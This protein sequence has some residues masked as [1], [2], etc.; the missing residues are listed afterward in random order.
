MQKNIAVFFGGV[1]GENEI[2]VITG[3]M[4][5]NVLRRGGYR[6]VPVY[7]TQSGEYVCGEALADIKNYA[8]GARPEG[9]AAAFVPG[10]LALLSRRGK[11]KERLPLYCAVNCCHGG[12]GEGGGISGLCRAMSVPLASAGVF[13]SAACLDKRLTKLLLSALG[14]P[15]L[16]YEYVTDVAGSRKIS[17]F[18]VVVKPVSL[19][20]SIGVVRADDPDQLAAAVAAA[21]ELDSG[22]IIERY[23]RDRRE[24]NC[25]VYASE[26]EVVVSPCEELRGGDLLTYDDKYSGGG[27]RIFPADIGRELSDRIRG[28]A[29]KVYCAFGMRGVVRMDFLAEGNDVYLSEINTVP[30][31]L[32]QYLVSS[33]YA[34]FSGVLASLIGRARADFAAERTK[35]LINTGIIN[36]FASNACKIK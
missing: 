29:R 11:I 28:C 21:L 36:N 25:A 19:G 33:D 16:D 15:A 30:G 8:G 17:N 32:S 13:E 23:V 24:Y 20:S 10:G 3:V 26:G 22:A 35:L 7:I 27:K 12:W 1:S 18:P 14:V 34:D 4:V 31:S 5:C 2:S 9:R 6:V